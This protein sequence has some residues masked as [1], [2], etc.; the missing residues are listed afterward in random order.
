MKR[1]INRRI[2]SFFLYYSGI[3]AVIL[4]I[5]KWKGHGAPLILV[6]HR[7]LPERRKDADASGINHMAL[8]SS[9]AITDHEFER[10]LRFIKR[11]REAGDPKDLGHGSPLNRAFYLTLDDGYLDNKN[12]AGPILRKLHI[13][14]I[15]FIVD[16]LL[17]R[18]TLLPWWDA[19]GARHENDHTKSSVMEYMKKCG[20]MKRGFM[21]LKRHKTPLAYDEDKNRKEWYISENVARELHK[22]GVF[23]I[24]NHTQSH[25]NLTC[26]PTEQ[27]AEE[28]LQG[29]AS[30]RNFPGYLPVLAYPFGQYDKRVLAFLE[31]RNDI[32]MAFAT[33]NG[34]NDSRFTMKRVNLNI[35]P[36]YLFAAE[37]AGI[38]HFFRKQQRRLSPV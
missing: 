25:A 24:A 35:K 38:F 34:A 12:V 3:V 22:D 26:L 32:T 15:I 30:I 1:L 11:F 18:P 14:A 8:L 16:E 31:S 33:G 17:H 2:L 5:M 19:W 21:G 13:K 20:D 9:H 28:I 27:I 7:V 23:Y 37:C 29:M 6:G 10:R 4:L 36:F